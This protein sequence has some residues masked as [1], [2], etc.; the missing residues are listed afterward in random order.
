MRT[1]VRMNRI[2]IGIT[3]LLLFPLSTIWTGS[4]R[5]QTQDRKQEIQELKDKLQQLDQTMG[6]VKARISALEESGQPAG[7]PPAS[8]APQP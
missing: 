8:T 4:V 2:T 3:T 5:A 1:N 7:Q 6:E